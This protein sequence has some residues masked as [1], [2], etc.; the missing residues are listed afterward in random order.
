MNTSTDTIRILAL[1]ITDSH[2]T[3]QLSDGRTVSNPLKW[4]P[5]LLNATGKDRRDFELSGDGYAVH[6]EKLDEDLS[7]SG[8]AAGIPSVE[9][10]HRSDA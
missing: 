5:R 7:A 2:L 3:A 8:V 6:W 10:R 1:A 4:Y 9:Y